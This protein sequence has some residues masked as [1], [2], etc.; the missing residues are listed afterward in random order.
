MYKNLS[1]DYNKLLELL[2]ENN[3]ILCFVNNDYQKILT[4]YKVVDENYEY[5][6]C[7]GYIIDKDN[8]FDY[9]KFLNLEYLW[10]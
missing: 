8:F 5:F 4:I 7:D 10:N 3:L 9:A 1:K 6:Y 2:N